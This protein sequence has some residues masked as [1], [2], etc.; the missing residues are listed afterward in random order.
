MMV[1]D[2][3]IA[4][5]DVEQWRIFGKGARHTFHV[6]GCSFKVIN[7]GGKA[8]QPWETGWKDTVI[9]S[10]KREVEFL[11]QFNKVASD[12]TPYMYHCHMLEHEDM[13]MMGQF[14]VG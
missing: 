2:E 14:T 12:A 4:L 7:R 10:G 11:V 13:G 1:I 6:H 9:V 3:K 8:P 5:G